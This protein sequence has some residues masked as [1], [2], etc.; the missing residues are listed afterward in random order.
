[1]IA[2]NPEF[3]LYGGA[4]GLIVIG[5]AGLV[6]SRHLFRV[7]LALVIAEAGANLLL[8]LAGFRFNALAPIA[9][10]GQMPASMV[11]PVPQAMVL[12]AIVIGVG[13]QALALSVVIRIYR[14]YGT[15]DMRVLLN[16]MEQDICD[17]AGI[18]APGSQDAPSGQR[19]ITPPEVVSVRQES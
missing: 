8:V 11:D 6:L 16:R 19:P 10:S 17:E 13:I 4:I 12:T 7:I 9:I 1:M 15:L 14:A 3:I 18:E 2:I 5:V